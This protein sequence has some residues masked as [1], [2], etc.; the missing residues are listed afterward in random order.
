MAHE[1]PVRNA[2]QVASFNQ[3]VPIP[4][5]LVLEMNRHRIESFP[6]TFEEDQA[7]EATV[8]VLVVFQPS[9]DSERVIDILHI[10]SWAPRRPCQI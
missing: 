5:H 6:S 3:E 4:A 7:N 1:G 8:S 9:P 2:V 10:V